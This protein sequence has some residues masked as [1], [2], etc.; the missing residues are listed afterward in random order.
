[1]ER[2]IA[3]LDFLFQS[4]VD[5]PSHLFFP[6]QPGKIEAIVECTVSHR[7]RQQRNGGDA[8]SGRTTGFQ[9][10]GCAKMNTFSFVD[11]Y[12]AN[13]GVLPAFNRHCFSF[14]AKPAA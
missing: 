11:E 10:C 14:A 1:M 3:P 9:R 7:N 13:R 4:D 2:S 12:S 8:P 5:S 6:A